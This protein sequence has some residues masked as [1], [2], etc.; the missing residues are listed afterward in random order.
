M[1]VPIAITTR[2][3]ATIDAHVPGLPT[4]RLLM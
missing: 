1:L 4:L 3:G 2:P